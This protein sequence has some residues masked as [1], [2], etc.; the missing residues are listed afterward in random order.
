MQNLHTKK[1]LKKIV[2]LIAGDAVEEVAAAEVEAIMVGETTMTA[3]EQT[4][5]R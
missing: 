5:R 4:K 2:K 3:P 1:N